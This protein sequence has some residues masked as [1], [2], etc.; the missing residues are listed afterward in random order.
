M[1]T[2]NP[3]MVADLKRFW[4]EGHSSGEISKRM[5]V[6]PDA[7]LAKL[8]ML[9]VSGRPLCRMK[10]APRHK[11]EPQN[12]PD[13]RDPDHR[14]DTRDLGMLAKLAGGMSPE[15]VAK[16]QRLPDSYTREL[17]RVYQAQDAVGEA[18]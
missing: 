7:V 2:W 16:A 14:I 10:G 6:S 5:R 13:P 17:W 15:A 8:S 1:T 3:D 18:A 11:L 12:T 9:G 4:A